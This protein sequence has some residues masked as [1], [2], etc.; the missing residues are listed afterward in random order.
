M[1]EVVNEILSAEKKVQASLDEARHRAAHMREECEREVASIIADAEA[2]ALEIT[3]R[4]VAAA[5]SDARL[6]REKTLEQ[7][8]ED[9]RLLSERCADAI[10]SLSDELTRLVISTRPP[11][12]GN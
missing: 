3:E 10:E 7:A 12:N 8:Q 11:D 4:T 6:Q 9:N 2:K 1:K 5:R